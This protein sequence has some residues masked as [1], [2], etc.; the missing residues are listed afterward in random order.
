MTTTRAGRAPLDSATDRF[1]I[2]LGVD[3]D[4][5][6]ISRLRHDV[7]AT[8][9]RQYPVNDRGRLDDPADSANAYIVAETGSSIIGFV[10]VT[11][12]WAPRFFLE[13]YYDP[14]TVAALRA[15]APY[16][17]RALT[18]H[19]RHRR[20]RTAAAIMYAALR[21]VIG[22]GGRHAV[23]M[24]RTEMRSMYQRVGLRPLGHRV[25]AGATTYELMTTDA[26]GAEAA[27]ER[28]YRRILPDLAER[29]D[30]ELDV[31]LRPP[32]A[33]LHGGRSFDAIGT[34]FDRLDARVSIVTADVLDAWF[35]PAPGV[36]AALREDVG[37]LAR[38][39][40]PARGDGLVAAIAAAR[41]VPA[42]SVVLG[43]GSSDLMYRA[44]AHLLTPR[45][46]VLLTRPTYGEYPHLVER[47]VGAQVDH[48]RLDPDDDWRLDLD[49]LRRTVR[50]HPY[51]LVVIVN[52]ANPSGGHVDPAALWDVVGSAPPTTL[53]WID[54]AYVDYVGRAGSSERTA[55]ASTNVI[56]CKS[57]SKVYALSGVR[58]AY[59]AAPPALAAELRRWSPPWPVS[60]P[61]Q[62][63][64]V[65]ALQDEPYYEGRWR[66][67]ASLR[68]DL[69]DGLRERAGLV[70]SESCANF[71]TVR[72]PRGTTAAA[73]CREVESAGVF[74]RDLTPLS[75]DYRGRHVRAAVRGPADNARVTAA[76]VDALARS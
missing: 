54:E 3:R 55:A 40:P 25:T 23:V 5:V 75:S 24:G 64:A 18:V 1:T 13:R 69:A 46:R 39:S 38:T 52:P 58:A 42:G 63:A 53:F 27:F 36:V 35:D 31:P 61:G 47:V 48:L 49:A 45:S 60:L 4:R 21:W 51:D 29:V 37:W 34:A 70:V 26:P 41:G 59:L 71:V 19:P 67:T 33:C 44:A 66:L 32:A 50:R 20:G 73:V 12:P 8:E 6:A 14:D 9:L 76:I 72:L 2:R 68:R 15:R 56:V 57:L 28:T 22:Q 17:V 43:A 7:Y 16:E 11:P 30:W 74:L 65:R 10:S 62:I